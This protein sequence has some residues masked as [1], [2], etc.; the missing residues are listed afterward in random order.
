[1]ARYVLDTGVLIGYVRRA[2]FAERIECSYAPAQPPNTALVPVVVE[3]ELRSMALRRQWQQEKL[4]K[5]DQLLR[6][7]PKVDISHPSVVARF[8]EID[9]YRL[10]KLANRPLPTGMSSQTIG[11][12]DLWVAAVAS[13]LNAILTPQT[14]IS[15]CSTAC[16]SPGFSSIRTRCR[17]FLNLVR[18]RNPMADARM[19][20]STLTIRWQAVPA[21]RASAAQP[22]RRPSEHTLPAFL[23]SFF[24]FV[25]HLHAA[26]RQTLLLSPAACTSG[27][28]SRA[29]AT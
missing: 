2:P 22:I 27:L 5:L 12:N 18:S 1:M 26:R 29:P 28:S 17:K 10:G 25:G 3:A 13:V 16:F 11:D 6:R 15:M 24:A 23:N 9:A 7:I 20:I 8:A 14:R 21:G 4:A 19:P